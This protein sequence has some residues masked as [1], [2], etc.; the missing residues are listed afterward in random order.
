MI[1]EQ[2][3]V[4]GVPI[5][6]SWWQAFGSLKLDALIEE[7]LRV[8]PTLDAAEATV[9]QARHLYDARARTDRYPQ[10]GLELSGERKA[11]NGAAMGQPAGDKTFNLFGA[12]ATIEY[13]FD[14]FGGNRRALEALAAQI[15]YQQF[16]LEG[17]RL[18]LVVNV[19]GVAI[20]QARLNAQ[21]D[22]S[23]QILKA[24][25][26]QLELTRRRLELGTASKVDVLVFQ[27]QT[28]Q[29][30]AGIF[31]LRDER[32]QTSHLLAMLVGQSSSTTNIASFALSDFRLPSELPLQI[33]SEWARQRPDIRASEALLQAASAEVGVAVANLYPQITLHAQ[34]GSQALSLDSL[35]GAGS[36]IWGLGGQLAQ[37][38]FNRGLRAEARAAEARYDA[39]AAYYR[40][41]ILQ[42]LRDVADNMRALEHHAHA[43]EARA[44]AASSARESLELLLHRYHMGAANYLDVLTAQQQQQSTL[45]DLFDSQAQ[46]LTDTLYFYSAMGGGWNQR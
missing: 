1:G 10:A 26:E 9:E 46:R 21:I 37:P 5:H 45:M 28:D 15:G 38:L 20:K 23:E 34:M 35:F 7:A 13:D 8:S 2:Q 30:R 29:I 14:L 41:T 27:T 33:P 36:L 3:F 40:E 32:D 24:Q 19:I 42:A 39:A 12:T 44:A 25:E 22:A 18:T 43:M 31:V 6:A 16:Q 17:A 4:E 11:I